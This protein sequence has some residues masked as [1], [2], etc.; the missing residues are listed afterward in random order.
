M[1]LRAFQLSRCRKSS[2][3]LLAVYV[4]ICGDVNH[5]DRLTHYRQ[6]C[7]AETHPGRAFRASVLPDVFGGNGVGSGTEIR[8]YSCVSGE[9]CL[10][11]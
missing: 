11:S 5:P 6:G 7:K 9:A 3:S 2:S 8:T 10:W 1:P 4:A